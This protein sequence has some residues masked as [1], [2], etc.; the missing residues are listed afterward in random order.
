MYF[1]L[2]TRVREE[3]VLRKKRL[4]LILAITIIIAAFCLTACSSA[5]KV[6]IKFD[7][8]GGT[9]VSSQKVSSD[10]E[11]LEL[12]SPT[13]KGYV[14]GG[15]YYDDACT[16]QVDIEV[17]P[18]ENVTFYARW[19]KQTIQVGFAAEGFATQY[20]YVSYGENLTEDMMPAVP[21][22]EGY[23]G[24]WNV[25]LVE[26][27]TEKVTVKAVYTPKIFTVKYFADGEVYASYEGVAGDTIAVPDNPTLENGLFYGWYY[28][29]DLTAACEE[30]ITTIGTEDVVLY[31]RFIDVTN[32]DKY[33]TYEVVDKEIA[34]TG[35]T[36]IGKGQKTIVIPSEISGVPVT[37]IAAGSKDSP[38]F[39]S[40][41]SFSLLIPASVKRIG[42]YAFANADIEELKWE[43][44]TEVIGEGAF[45]GCS[46]LASVSVPSTVRTIGSYAF[47]ENTTLTSVVF[48]SGSRLESMGEKV[49]DGVVLMTEVVIPDSDAYEIDYKTFV[50]SFVEKFIVTKEDGKYL[51]EDGV[52]YSRRKSSDETTG[53]IDYETLLVFPPKKSGEYVIADETTEIAAGAFFGNDI[54][55]GVTIGKNVEKIGARAFENCENIVVVDIKSAVLN[56]IGERAFAYCGVGVINLP[57]SLNIVGTEAFA[58]SK[59][60]NVYFADGENTNEFTI[61]ERAFYSCE[62]LNAVTIPAR[63]SEIASYAFYDCKTLSAIT[64][65][66]GSVLKTISAY[67]FAYCDKL[68]KVSIP[69]GVTTIGNY[70]FYGRENLSVAEPNIPRN[71]NHIGDYAFA[72]TKVATYRADSNTNILYFGEGAFYNCRSL[73]QL[74]LPRSTSFAK[75]PDYAFY[76]CSGLS[77][78]TFNGNVTEIGNYAFYGCTNLSSVTFNQNSSGG[79]TK[80]GDG[81]FENCVKLSNGGSASRILPMMLTSLGKRAFYGCKSLEQITIPKNLKSI[82]PEAFAGCVALSKIYYDNDC[83]TD[84]LEE[85]CF[86][87]CTSLVTVVLPEKLALRKDGGAVKNPFDGCTSLVAFEISNNEKITVNNGVAYVTDGS[88]KGIYLYPTGKTGEFSIGT[89]VTFIDSYA[90]AGAKNLS[91]IKFQTNA[92]V[93]GKTEVTL[94]KIND[95]AFYNA[96]LTEADISYRVYS[97]GS[98]AFAESRLTKAT[99]DD[100]VVIDGE[101]FSIKN[102]D[103]ASKDNGL[104]IGSYSFDGT[105]ITELSL[106]KRVTVIDEG[107]FKNCYYLKT[108]TFIEDYPKGGATLG[109][110]RKLNVGDY[111]FE[112]ASGITEIV[113]PSHVSKIGNRAFADCYNV[114]NVVFSE[115]ATEVTLGSYA[116]AGNHYLYELVLQ[117][118]IKEMGEGVFS[119]C[120]RLAEVTFPTTIREMAIAIPDYAFYGCYSLRKIE[121]PSYVT[122]IGD[123]AFDGL[124]LTE[125]TIADKGE[126]LSVGS[127]AFAD[128]KNLTA[129]NL[130]S[131]ITEINSYAFCGSGLTEVTFAADGSDGVTVSE[132]AFAKTSIENIVIPARVTLKGS[133]VFAYTDNLVS[134]VMESKDNGE[135]IPA[136]TFEESSLIYLTV[137]GKVTSIGEYAFRNAVGIRNLEFTAAN[138]FSIGESAFENSGIESVTIKN[139]PSTVSIKTKAFYLASSLTGFAVTA[140]SLSIGDFAFAGS[141]I[142]NLTLNA[143][144]AEKSSSVGAGI[145]ANADNLAEIA[146]NDANGGFV[147]EGGILYAVTENKKELV[148]YPAGKK[149]AV[150]ILSET[151]TKVRDYAFG[152]NA[153]LTT[154]AVP[155]KDKMVEFTENAFAE[156]NDI[157]LFVDEERIN[158]YGTNVNVASLQS[159]FN[160]LSLKSVGSGRYAVTGYSGDADKIVIPGKITVDDVDFYI[161]KI[162]KNAFKNNSTATEITIGAGITEIEEYAF[163]GAINLRKVSLGDNVVTIKNHAFDGCVNLTE[164]SLGKSVSSVGDYAFYNCES[165]SDVDM[166]GTAIKNIGAYA[167]GGCDLSKVVM[168]ETVVSIGNNAFERN[169]NLIKINLPASVKSIGSYVFD[170]CEK[171][172]FVFIKSSAVPTVKNTSFEGLTD[173]L[174]LF[175]SSYAE[176]LYKTDSVFRNYYE[177]ILSYDDVSEET[178]FENYVLKENS[179]GL[180]LVSY[181]GTEKSVVLDTKVGDK[182]TITE[183]A[184]YAFGLF[185]E[186]I[187]LSDGIKRIGKNA[188]INAVNLRKIEFSGSEETIGDY[189]FYNLDYLTDVSFV[190]GGKL[191]KI[192]K[193][194]FAGCDSLTSTALPERT[195]EIGDYAFYASSLREIEIKSLPT[196]EMTI[197]KYAFSGLKDLKE[198]SFACA[199]SYLGDGAFAEDIN[200]SAIYL[201]STGSVIAKIDE[202]SL[203]VFKDCDLLCVYVPND[204]TLRAYRTTGGWSSQ[205]DKNRL[206]A[207]SYLA[208]DIVDET[209]SVIKSQQGFVISP[210][211]STNVA[212]IISYVGTD[213]VV[214]FPST[215]TVNGKEY[216]INK[217]GREENN[218]SSVHNGRVISDEVTEIIVPSSVETIG[219]D[220][221]RGA[222]GLRRVVCP[223]DGMLKKIGSYAFAYCENLEEVTLPKY[224]VEIGSYAFAYDDKLASVTV[225]E[226]SSY[227]EQSYLIISE[228]AFTEDKGLRKITFPKHLTT[229]GDYAFYKCENLSEAILNEKGKT[230]S[231]GKYALAYTAIKELRLPESVASLNDGALAYAENLRAVR[232]N[233][234]I[235]D[236]ITSLTTAGDNLFRGITSPFIK[237]YVPEVSYSSYKNATGWDAGTVIPDLTDYTEV[238]GVITYGDYNYRVNGNGTITSNNTTV[239]I[240]NYLGDETEVV[241]PVS[242]KIGRYECKVTALDPYFGN[243]E[244]TKFTFAEGS[245]VTNLNAYAFAGCVSLKKVVLP[246]NVSG[247][248]GHV[249]SG[250]TALTDVTLSNNLTKIPEYAFSGCT[251]LREIRIPS[252]VKTIDNAAFIYCSSLN[253][254]NVEFSTVTSLGTSALASTNEALVI[255]VPEGRRD[256]F[257]N[258]WTDWSDKIYD[259]TARYGD[260]VLKDNGNGFTLMQYNG[261][262]EILDLTDRTIGGKK[263]TAVE[264]DAAVNGTTIII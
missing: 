161:V 124:Y 207:L 122:Q 47:A 65:A 234:T 105:R 115:E 126:N 33:F 40:S 129:I 121:I 172:A 142:K 164:V 90:F 226:L 9:S 7:S 223:D 218:S 71:V 6:T 170:G 4:T 217:I 39:V 55:T 160:G 185:T 214:T 82:S 60:N 41:R 137:G 24:K 237:I 36:A 56:S 78:V 83:I 251:A 38:T 73:T 236:G 66:E 152:G 49:F 242:L 68:T 51:S 92:A 34:V 240:T 96:N 209:G 261:F 194:A 31:A 59:V 143:T 183:I 220:A 231:I 131:R 14:F 199:V 177:K 17:I 109:D 260:F 259:M 125:V 53:F 95:Y 54:I 189:A 250:C 63:A 249:F 120:G 123:H 110:E 108:L 84:T 254:L 173:S 116:F 244:I 188:F 264:A 256:A 203:D 22:K 146:F 57:A 85:N 79:V 10:T 233:R 190:A 208:E 134:V 230:S 3:K 89:D 187:V 93:D 179:D 224:L 135:S 77:G 252:S 239:T 167:F 48:E 166:S 37:S 19:I 72:N 176:H 198:M 29:E 258:E 263:I 32:I 106:P 178:G 25:N 2:R 197:G 27:V 113:L 13:K 75:V 205:F 158:D 229:I 151:V 215:V 28:D 186:E 5:G 245:M 255:I 144:N 11:K 241:I 153:Y 149:G 145:A 130:P 195:E 1:Y 132:Y 157:T 20:V 201:G 52:I 117:A 232:I 118:G 62:K 180:T 140:G 64:F 94:V 103:I 42:S 136:S 200:L 211:G 162:G 181:L 88:E 243:E 102:K 219:G 100:T 175:V 222:K 12:P 154:V 225:A 196:V 221:F 99:F 133:G 30:E 168:G 246:D 104:T 43:E 61:A 114:R 112:G 86:A 98:S 107:A 67:A 191:K 97:I 235:K 147:C 213:T 128:N 58:Y 227:D 141:G 262:A 171:L 69:S 228:Y 18:K 45:F 21:E 15:W 23:T 247:A 8:M 46:G 156:A 216:T 174:K 70:A 50:G 87:D 192:G 238:N 138:E 76:G 80:I 91:T 253:R 184:E 257:A 193:Y 165:L 148:Q 210:V 139:S 26:N 159:K 206:V 127:Y 212:S 44:G 101:T 150:L 111:A 74:Q 119:D 163:A 202:N 16:Q 169:V 248:A 81:A 155:Q 182:G 35:L 204:A